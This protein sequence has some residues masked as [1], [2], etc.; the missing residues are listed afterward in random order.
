MTD[1]QRVLMRWSLIALALTL[2][3]QVAFRDFW[4]LEQHVLRLD[5]SDGVERTFSWVGVAIL[6]IPGVLT[7]LLGLQRAFSAWTNHYR[8][9][10]PPGRGRLQP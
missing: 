9:P 5:G 2:L 10:A 6:C 7:F 4:Y 8:Q 3:M 1:W